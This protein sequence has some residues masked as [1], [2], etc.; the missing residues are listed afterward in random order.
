MQLAMEVEVSVAANAQNDN[1][2][3]TQRYERMP[4]DGL[5]TLYATGSAA[6]LRHELN[7]GGR[8]ITPQQPVNTGNRSPIVP[9]D[10]IVSQVEAFQGELVQLTARNTTAG[11]LTYRARAILEEGEVEIE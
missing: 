9:D 2:F 1:V 11:A 4:F 5:L 7:V 3:S 6:G 8:S 10:L